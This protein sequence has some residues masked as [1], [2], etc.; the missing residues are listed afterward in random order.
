VVFQSSFEQVQPHFKVAAQ[1]RQVQGLVKPKFPVV[2]QGPA[3]AEVIA[4]KAPDD[5]AGHASYQ[6]GMI[7]EH[8]VVL[9]KSANLHSLLDSR[10]HAVEG[11]R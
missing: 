3:I 1:F 8:A 2:E 9:A 11:F 7:D 4:Q 5:R 6:I 10:R